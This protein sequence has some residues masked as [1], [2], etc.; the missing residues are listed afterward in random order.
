MEI[1]SWAP[2]EKDAPSY[3][4]VFICDWC[5]NVAYA[6]PVVTWGI[7]NS[8]T[9]DGTESRIVGIVAVPVWMNSFFANHRLNRAYE[10]V[11][12]GMRIADDLPGFG[13]YVDASA[14]VTFIHHPEGGCRGKH[15]RERDAR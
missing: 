13:G 3:Y 14:L 15:N 9:G 5:G 11:F 2:G 8:A 4:A 7:A 1:V 12:V 10:D 6:L